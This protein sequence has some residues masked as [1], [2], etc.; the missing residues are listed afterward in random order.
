MV[1]QVLEEYE[2][3]EDRM[4]EYLKVVKTLAIGFKVFMIKHIAR[5][6]NNQAN[7]LAY[8]ASALD[9]NRIAMIKHL[10]KPSV[11]IE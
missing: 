4:V 5:E 8:L 11:Q 7:R 1:E 2:A 6:H 3:K 10:A 9:N